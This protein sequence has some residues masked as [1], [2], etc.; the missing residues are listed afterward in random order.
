MAIDGVRWD[1]SYMANDEENHALIADEE[2]PTE[3]ALMTKTSA[4]SEVFDNS[5][6]SIA[7]KKNSDSLNR[8][9]D[10]SPPPAQIYFPPK[11]DMSWTGLPEC[12]DDTVT[13]YSRPAPSIESFPDDAQNRNP[14]ITK[15]EA[16]PSSFH[17]NLSLSLRRQMTVQLK[18][19]QIK[20]RQLRNP[21][22]SPNFVMK[23]KACFNCGDFNHLAY[24]C[25]KRVK[26]GTSRS[27]NNTHKSFTP[28]PV[29]H[30]PYRPP[31]RL[32]RPNMN[33]AQPN[34]TSFNKPLGHSYN[35]MPFQRTSSVRSQ[36]R[37]PWVSTVNI[38]FPTVNRKFPTANRKFLT[39]G[40]KLST[41]NMGKKGKADMCLLVKEDARLLAKELL[42]LNSVLFTDSE[43]IVLGR[44]FKLLDD[45]NVLLRTPRQH[46]MYSINLNNI[47]PHKDLAC[48]V[49][50]ASADEER[51]DGVAI[52]KRQRQDFQSDGVMVL[53]MPSGR[54]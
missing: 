45:A 46:N 4:K 23:K 20:L 47:V 21:L 24:D 16:L 9:S 52:T 25:S 5:L 10:V 51:G 50:K 29:V 53:V 2:T 7:C 6:C 31:M 49:A 48:L 8:Y 17:L 39:G 1:W 40:T 35:K 12:A 28:R 26:K 15:T 44:D 41:A 38:N 36:F 34:R 19:R 32:I 42:K 14:S 18:V 54:R 11:K 27:R 37:A 3:F 33:A 22:L 13:N 43:C 30:R